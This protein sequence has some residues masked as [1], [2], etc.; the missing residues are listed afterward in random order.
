MIRESARAEDLYPGAA[1]LFR[2]QADGYADERALARAAH[3]NAVRWLAGLV[4]VGVAV[5]VGRAVV[6]WMNRNL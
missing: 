1:P 4:A 2:R 3:P 5:L 6:G